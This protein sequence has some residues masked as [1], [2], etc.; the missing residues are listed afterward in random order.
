[1]FPAVRH[2]MYITKRFRGIEYALSS[3]IIVGFL[4]ID[5]NP[6]YRCLSGDPNFLKLIF[7]NE[8]IIAQSGM[9][10]K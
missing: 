7:L 6:L 4:R 9:W 8:D 1:M 5:D 10:E 3:C 2:Q